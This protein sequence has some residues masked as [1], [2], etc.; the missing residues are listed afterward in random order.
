MTKTSVSDQISQDFD[1]IRAQL[2]LT[3]DRDHVRN[4]DFASHSELIQS[5]PTRSRKKAMFRGCD[6][7]A[8]ILGMHN[9]TLLLPAAPSF[10]QVLDAGYISL[11]QVDETILINTLTAP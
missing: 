3:K 9:E 8:A 2:R 5:L 7:L 11:R 10:G 1:S 6:D 4:D